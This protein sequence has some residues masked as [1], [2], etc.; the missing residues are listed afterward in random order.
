M[1]ANRFTGA[2]SCCEPARFYFYA[3]I[4]KMKKFLKITFIILLGLAIVFGIGI[5][6]IYEKYK[7][8]KKIIIYQDGGSAKIIISEPE[9]KL[10]IEIARVIKKFIYKEAT[11]HNP[12][13]DVLPDQIDDN[14]I[15]DIK[16]KVE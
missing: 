12:E 9:K 15:K 11:I 16:D 6:W 8:E 1:Q 4:K 14:I 7:E 3:I 5:F 2:G 13:G 10:L